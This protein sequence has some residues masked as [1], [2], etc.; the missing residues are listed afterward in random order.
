MIVRPCLGLSGERCALL[1][2][3]NR[4][5]CSRHA[6]IFDA[7][8]QAKR[9]GLYQGDYP[10]RARAQRQAQPFCSV[11]GSTTDLTADHV[12]AGVV[13]SPLRTLCRGCNAARANRARATRKGDIGHEKF[14]TLRAN[15]PL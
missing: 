5:R 3:T 1:I 4:R 7:N 12:Y 10:A 9:G 15:T 14:R 11:C 13:D 6:L 2:P 8:R